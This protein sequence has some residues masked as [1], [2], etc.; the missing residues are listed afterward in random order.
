MSKVQVRGR[1]LW[2]DSAWRTYD[3]LIRLGYTGYNLENHVPTYMKRKWVWEAYSA[4]HD[5]VTEDRFYGMLGQSA[6]LNHSL[7]YEKRPIYDLKQEN[8]RCGFYGKM[9]AYEEIFEKAEGK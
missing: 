5:F 3:T 8:S 9:P 7:R 1:G 2:I 6:I 4:F